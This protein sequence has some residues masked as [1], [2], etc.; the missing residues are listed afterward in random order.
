MSREFQNTIDVK[1]GK[2]SKL[3]EDYKSLYTKWETT[4]KYLQQYKDMEKS[5]DLNRSK[6]IKS[7]LSHENSAQGNP[8]SCPMLSSSQ[9]GSQDDA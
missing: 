2:Y 7:K 3:K 5:S 1:D 6:S 8:A 9:G 4:W